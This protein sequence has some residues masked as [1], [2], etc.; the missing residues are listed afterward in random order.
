MTD[1]VT[2]A[3]IDGFVSDDWT[4]RGKHLSLP[5]VAQLAATLREMAAIVYRIT[6]MREGLPNWDED[7]CVFCGAYP[8]LRAH[9]ADC[10]FIRARK[11]MG[12]EP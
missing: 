9:E 1:F 3:Q 6:D 7:S 2:P 5:F 8:P 11:L 10:A 4:V 12:L